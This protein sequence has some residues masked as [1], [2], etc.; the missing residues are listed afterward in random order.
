[1]RFD[2]KKI[3][4]ENK[5][6]DIIS[7]YIP[8]KADGNEFRGLCPFHSE[9]SA[10][11]TISDKKG[12]FHCFGCG[13]HGDIIDFVRDINSTDFR[14]A[15]E[16]L[17]GERSH[18][19]QVE[20]AIKE[21]KKDV[22]YEG[23]VPAVG[24]PDLSSA[25]K[26][27]V[28]NPKR[29]QW[30]TIAP[31]MK[32]R[33]PDDTGY[34][35]R[36][37]VGDG[38]ITPMIRW[39]SVK[40][41]EPCWCYM[42]FDR[43]RRLYGEELLGGYKG[44]VF[45]V[46]GEKAADAAN[47]ILG[48]PALAWSGGAEA[49]K[50]TDFSPLKDRPVVL[51]CDGDEQGQGAMVSL[52]ERLYKITKDIKII[53]WDKSRVKGWDAADAETEGLEK[54]DILVW[55]KER[56][57]K[58]ETA[59]QE[60][61][62]EPNGG[63]IDESTFLADSVQSDYPATSHPKE[64]EEKPFKILGHDNGMYYFHPK[65]G[66]QIVE[67]TAPGLANI[68]NLFRLNP[69]K[70]YFRDRWDVAGKSSFGTIA[71]NAAAD[72]IKEAETI[73]IFRPSLVR[74]TGAWLDKGEPV[75]HAGSKLIVN[76]AYINPSSFHSKY[77]YPLR[78]A[79]FPMIIEP[80]PSKEAVKLREI[81]GKISWD[82][83]LSGELLAGW[84]VIAPVCGALNWRP[85]I[86]IEG[87]SETGKSTVIDKILL[88]MMADV[89]QRFEGGTTEA[90][91]RQTL[92]VN[93]L[94]VIYDEAEPENVKDRL[95]MDGLLLLARKS[96]SGAKIAKGGANGKADSFTLRS[97]FCFAGINPAIKQRADESRISRLI[98]R[99]AN[100][101]GADE[102]YKN[103]KKEIAQTI[104]PEYNQGMISR[105]VLNLPTLLSN[106]EVFT[107]ACADTMGS[108]RAADQIGPMIAGL[109]LLTSTKKVNY[110]KAVEW[111]KQHDWTLHTAIAEQSDPE[112]LISYISSHQIRYGGS[113]QKSIGTMIKS[114]LMD[115]TEAIET[116]R[117]IGIWPKPS[118]VLIINKSPRLSDILRDTP[119]VSWQRSLMDIDGA[120]K[121]TAALFSPGVSGRGTLVP[122]KAFGL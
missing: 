75:I 35:V 40:G 96:S 117:E 72:I 93:A 57:Y 108:R 32:F 97:C 43:P 51:W 92:G 39:V 110:D 103:L 81:C 101:A 26:I 78:E 65:L 25:E 122:L 118:G 16:I 34:V 27:R 98:I 87:Q 18:G 68:A 49:H 19:E 116:L 115:D 120:I 55:M 29:Q 33:Y 62:P 100:F 121:N 37:D 119:W 94:P 90:A 91:I 28:W 88:P 13:A 6:S 86:W 105:T 59:Q 9:K 17:G 2:A 11:F 4:E 64:I 106:C 77:I 84:I 53:P 74:G 52:A 80:L 23:V 38:K 82:T 20:S 104:T 114:A 66:G 61:L 54:A 41:A 44:Q 111:V 73:G 22:A 63:V 58:Y 99:K 56:A 46:E 1:M 109:Y 70:E 89:G 47:R 85:H 3:A 31:V 113:K 67:L 5:L 69:D 7:K 15:C 36:I 71:R 60:N 45:L 24:T 112:R 95:I 102:F 21:I 30:A 50:H 83:R 42:A 76:G 107:E 14:G 10:S 79:T 48:Y 8:I 12:F